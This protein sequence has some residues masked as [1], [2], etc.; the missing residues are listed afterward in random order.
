M[1]LIVFILALGLAVGSFVNV[2]SLRLPRGLSIVK[3]RSRCPECRHP[4]A[5]YDLIPILSFGLLRGRCRYCQTKIGWQYPLVELG[6]ALLVVLAAS[7]VAFP[8]WQ[9]VPIWV[10]GVEL[11]YVLLVVG[12]LVSL[13]VTDLRFGLLPDR[14]VLPVAGAVLLY[15]IFT[16]TY[17]LGGLYFRL[18][19]D[20]GG[21]GPFLLLQTPFFEERVWMEIQG[22]GWVVG[23]GV[24]VSLF[25][26]LLTVA[27]KGRGM[28]LGDVKLGMLIGLV[29]GW[30]EVWAAVFLAFSVGALVSVVLLVTGRKRFGETVP[31]G[32]FL[33]AGTLV[34]WFWGGE[35]L[36]WYLGLLG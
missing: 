24:L 2:V 13:F 20:V 16:T 19:N 26:Y 31:F 10:S 1:V 18:K 28:G 21:L 11:L 22:L 30:P 32:P 7:E 36:G 14:I 17:Q 34:S 15:R 6:T 3:R 35:I 12:A 5:W 27:T 9:E 33:V 8:G 23:G 25:F 29:V 4:L